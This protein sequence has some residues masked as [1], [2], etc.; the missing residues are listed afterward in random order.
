MKSFY[1]R[2]FA[3]L[4]AFVAISGAQATD[5]DTCK[6][7]TSCK[8]GLDVLGPESDKTTYCMIGNGVTTGVD[9]V[10]FCSVYY[11]DCETVCEEKMNSLYDEYT[12]LEAGALHRAC[13]TVGDAKE[14]AS[15]CSSAPTTNS[16]PSMHKTAGLLLLSVTATLSMFS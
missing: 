15:E 4:L 9:G 2:L 12:K 11:S 1:S 10:A 13:M 7:I 16:V 8:P 14:K 3:T 6:A 5:D